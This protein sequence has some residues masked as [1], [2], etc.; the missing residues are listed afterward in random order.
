MKGFLYR[1]IFFIGWL[2]SPLTFWNDSFVNIPISYIMAN[3]FIKI[4]PANFLLL[5]LAFYWLSNGLGLLLMYAGGKKIVEEKKSLVRS[6]LTILATIAIY[7]LV[8]FAL[9]R[10]GILKPI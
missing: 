8:L 9:E 10:I 1:L 3:I 4:L 7:T 2:L 6:V 5:L